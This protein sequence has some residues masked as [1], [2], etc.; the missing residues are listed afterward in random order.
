MQLARHERDAAGVEHVVRVPSAPRLHVGDDRGAGRDALEIVDREVDPEIAGDRD[1]VQHGVCGATGR[2]D[3]RHRVL[4]RL[5]R[6]ERA[7]RHVVTDELHGE[8]PGLVRRLLLVAVH[9]GDPVRPERR[10]PEEVE[11]RRHRVRGELT[12]A[13]ARAGARDRL[14]LVQVGIT[15]RAGGVGADPLVHVAD[16]HLTVAV[17]TRGD[18]AGVR[19]D[20]GNVEPARSHRTAGVGLV[21]RHE[22]D[23]PVEEMAARHELDRV[24]D[25]LARDERGAHAGGPHRDAVRDRDRVELH[26][27]SARVAHATLDVHR[28]VALIEVARHRLDP[29]RADTD[30]G[31]RQILV[32]EARALQHRACTRAVGAVGERCAVAFGRIRWAVVRGGRGLGRHG[33]PL[34]MG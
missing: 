18:R 22:L 15:H 11:D 28:E 3:R 14:E 33:A 7:R 29:G 31:L 23:E 16:R 5:L 21:T 10:Q 1:E 30:D 4:E 12:A 32:G 17:D 24:R 20:G 26:R 27:G 19:D 2:G 25:H 34:S 13:G 8:S 9:G 6:D